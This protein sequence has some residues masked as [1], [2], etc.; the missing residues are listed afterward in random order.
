MKRARC[1]ISSSTS[2][3][4]LEGTL[5]VVIWVTTSLR[6][7]SS[8][9]GVLLV[10]WPARQRPCRGTS[11][12]ADASVRARTLAFDGI[13][14]VGILERERLLECWPRLDALPPVRN[15]GAP[16]RRDHLR[17]RQHVDA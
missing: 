1:S 2:D 11:F 4:F 6:S 9:M 15:S 8:G 7:L 16:R 5:T 17:A 10:P 3:W 12:R 13:A 14:G